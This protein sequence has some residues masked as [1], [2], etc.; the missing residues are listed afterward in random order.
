M[1]D[2]ATEFYLRHTNDLFKRFYLK[3]KIKECALIMAPPQLILMSPSSLSKAVN[4]ETNWE[5]SKLMLI[6]MV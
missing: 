6:E 1:C 3:L 2:G 5:E 4:W